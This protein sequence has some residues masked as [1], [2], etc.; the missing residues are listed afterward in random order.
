MIKVGSENLNFWSSGLSPCQWTW[1]VLLLVWASRWGITHSFIIFSYLEDQTACQLN[2]KC[3]DFYQQGCCK[4][5]RSNY[6]RVSPFWLTG[7]HSG[8]KATQC[9][10]EHVSLKAGFCSKW[11][12]ERP[13]QPCVFKLQT[14]ELLMWPYS[15]LLILYT[16]L[17]LYRFTRFY[18]SSTDSIVS[19]NDSPMKKWNENSMGS[20][21]QKC[22]HVDSLPTVAV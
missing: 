13:G 4:S 5:V 15:I 10:F 14:V 6:T 3:G 19:V 2:V 20:S 12:Q 9:L 21:R 22:Q 7:F 11:V 17:I 1:I 18:W 8:K 16:W